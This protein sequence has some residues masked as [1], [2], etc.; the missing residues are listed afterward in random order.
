MNFRKTGWPENLARNTVCFSVDVEWAAEAVVEDLCRLFREHGIAATF[1]VTHAGVLAPGHE[2]GLHPNFRRAGET[3]RALPD[4]GVRT[5][6]EV[7]E[8]VLARTHA[9]A[10]EA[11]GVRSHCLYYDSTLLPL[12]RRRGIEYDC[13]YQLPLVEGL[14]PFWKHHGIVEIPTYYADHFDL[15]TQASGFALTALGLDRPG[16]KVFDFHPNLI[17]LNAPDEAHY[18]VTK[19]FYHD[20]ERLRAARYPGRGVRSL[21]IELLDHVAARGL[22][23]ATLGQVNSLWRT[24]PPWGSAEPPARPE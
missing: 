22:P 9:F 12:Y 11:K 8:H 20:A 14:R 4:A 6:S 1:F 16:I 23:V 13:T 15:L 7:H 17:Y 21:L 10:P 3:Y 19:S 18:V 2:R 24:I 5:D